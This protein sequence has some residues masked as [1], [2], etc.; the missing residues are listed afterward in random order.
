MHDVLT[1]LAELLEPLR[2]L[3]HVG[4]IR[5]KGLMV[6]IELVADQATRRP[7]DP[8]QRVG[9]TI[10]RALRN[11]GI[12]LRPLGD[13]V[14]LMPPLAMPAADLERLV[15]SLSRTISAYRAARS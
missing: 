9:A 14:V 13:T 8:G 6:G 3:P 11:D 4:D 2:R 1:R 10:C 5:Q 15:T 7:F 12:L